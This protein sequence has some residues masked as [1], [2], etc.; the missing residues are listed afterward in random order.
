MK[1][2][3][4]LLTALIMIADLH[5]EHRKDAVGTVSIQTAY[6]DQAMCRAVGGILVIH[7]GTEHGVA[8]ADVMAID[9]Y[10]LAGGLVI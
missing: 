5:V 9:R 8:M 3:W 10:V 6:T 2:L 4:I 1:R 7:Q